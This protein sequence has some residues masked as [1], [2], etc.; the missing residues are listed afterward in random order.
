MDPL[1]EGIPS[2]TVRL[3]DR[4]Y[5]DPSAVGGYRGARTLWS[6]L[7]SQGKSVPY[8][9]VKRWLHSRE[10]Y[11]LHKSH[12]SKI[13]RIP[14]MVPNVNHTLQADLMD[15]SNTAAVNDG[16][17]FLLTAVDVFSNKGYAIPL[18]SKSGLNVTRGLDSI[19]SEGFLFLHTDKGK[20]FLNVNVKRLVDR[21]GVTHYTTENENIKAGSV[22][23]F[24][25]TLRDVMARWMDHKRSKRYIDVLQRLVN[26]HNKTPHSRTGIAPVDV[27][28]SDANE[29]W[30]RRYERRKPKQVLT[31]LMLGDHVRLV[32][33]RSLFARG[34][35]EKW[36]REVFVVS[37][38]LDET[39]P[40]TYRVVDL[41][42]EPIDGRFYAQELQ[43]IIYDS[44][45]EFQIETVIKRRRRAGV[46][47]CLVKWMGYPSK[48][49][50]WV[51]SSSVA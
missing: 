27:T 28:T 25:R 16:T 22:E 51:P 11:T 30:I 46:N 17:K 3:L 29:L 34:Y 23:R 24:N 10:E 18:E 26:A 38:V 32:R 5:H 9:H 13:K 15:V 4:V 45:A 40:V 31:S 35:D 36:T 44:D 33:S 14:F 2:A 48:F 47:E 41:T 1:L 37:K 7:K 50:S 49:N 21:L 39:D 8:D 19:L 6:S 42:D 12:N 43:R 20:E